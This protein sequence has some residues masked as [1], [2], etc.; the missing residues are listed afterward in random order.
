MD[1]REQLLASVV[2]TIKDY[3]KGEIEAPTVDHVNR[4]LNQFTSAN[5]LPF[6]REFDY[7][8]KH[9]FIT[10]DDV[11]EYFSD[12]VRD[13]KIVGNILPRQFW[14]NANFL[15]IQENGQSQRELLGVMDKC[16]QKEFNMSL[17]ECFSVD[18]PFIYLDD[19]IYTGNRLKVDLIKWIETS[20]PVAAD[21][22][23]IV[24]ASHEGAYYSYNEILKAAKKA[25]KAI[26]IF[27]HE[28]AVLENRLR[29]RDHSKVLWPCFLPATPEIQERYPSEEIGFELRRVASD[30]VWPFSQQ[31]KRSI[32]EE[33]FLI[34]GAKILSRCES[35]SPIIRPL[36]FGSFEPGFGS[37][38]ASYRNCPNNSPLA[39]WWGDG[40]Q[41][42]NPALSWYPLLPR[43]TYT[44]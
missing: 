5:Q 16:L 30:S 40:G 39:L 1:E 19:V 13:S 26:K 34:A 20:A 23:I 21:V 22:H 43:T 44:S 24:F 10:E 3:R 37:M 14:R 18:G 9:S 33:E 42:G 2:E 15:N 4:W 36:G 7:V 25:N 38:I 29:Y 27:R 11:E 6:L 32:L 41:S 35:S 8:M 28:I 31:D 17:S 12:K